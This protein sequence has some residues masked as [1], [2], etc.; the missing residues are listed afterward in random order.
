M[1]LMLQAH[2]SSHYAFSTPKTHR[3]LPPETVRV[4][5]VRVRVCLVS[6]GWTVTVVIRVY[7]PK[8][9]GLGSLGQR[10]ETNKH[11]SGTL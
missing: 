1:D 9:Q 5:R 11:L 4:V 6:S 2:T 8:E 7:L 10:L 3:V